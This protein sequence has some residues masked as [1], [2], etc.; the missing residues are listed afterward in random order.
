VHVFL[1]HGNREATPGIMSCHSD[2]PPGT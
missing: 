2:V 1:V